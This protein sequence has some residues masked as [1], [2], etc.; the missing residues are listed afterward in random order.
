ME[1]FSLV[2]RGGT[3]SHPKEGAHKCVPQEYP[4]VSGEMVRHARGSL[5][6]TDRPGVKR[7]KDLEAEKVK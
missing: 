6:H 2:R 1:V 7:E 5:Q 3:S 4:Q